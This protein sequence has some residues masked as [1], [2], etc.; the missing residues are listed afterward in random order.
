[1]P[2]YEYQCENCS[3]KFESL[4]SIKNMKEPESEPCPN[5][6]IIGAVSQK[7]FTAQIW[8]DAHRVGAK[9]TDDGF[10]EVLSR[11]HERSPGSDLGSKLSRN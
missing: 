5:C 3:H 2:L 8:A 10:K 4:R 6:S 7:V 9:T 11:I 1:M